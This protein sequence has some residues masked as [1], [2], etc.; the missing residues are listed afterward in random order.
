[1]GA[2]VPARP[3]ALNSLGIFDLL[4]VGLATLAGCSLTMPRLLRHNAVLQEH[5]ADYLLEAVS[6]SGS[7]RVHRNLIEIVRG[8]QVIAPVKP[9]E[10][11][12]AGDTLAFTGDVSRLDLL[13]HALREA[14]FCGRYDVAVVALRRWG[15]RLRGG[16]GEV[17]LAAGD[18][19]TLVTGPGFQTRSC[20]AGDFLVLRLYPVLGLAEP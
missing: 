17:P 3:R 14:D 7:Q 19:L 10:A 4:P 2:G 12:Q 11:L 9:D 13:L 6:Q 18:S 8:G 20:D 16:L 5:P 15:Q 1:V